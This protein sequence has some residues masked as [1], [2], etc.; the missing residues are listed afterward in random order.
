MS[1]TYDLQPLRVVLAELDVVMDDLHARTRT[2]EKG[3][4]TLLKSDVLESHDSELDTLTQSAGSNSSS[5]SSG[6]LKKIRRRRASPAKTRHASPRRR[7]ETP[8]PGPGAYNVTMFNMGDKNKTPHMF[9][10]QRSPSPAFV[11]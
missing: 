9:P 6:S 4:V 8:S 7:R 1:R 11:R 3:V 10:T 2:P 5:T